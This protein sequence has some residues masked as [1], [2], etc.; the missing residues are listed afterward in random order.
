MNQRRFFV[1]ISWIAISFLIV[2][3]CSKLT[4][5]NS[6]NQ[7]AQSQNKQSKSVELTVSAAASIQ[8]AM[9]EVGKAYQEEHTNKKI[10]YNFANSGTLTQQIKQG[11]PVD[12]FISANEKFM[13]ELDKINLLFPETRK[14]ILKNDIV[15]IIPKKGNI[16]NISNFQQLTSSNIKRFSIGEPESVP[17]GRYARQVLTSLKIY[18]Q[19]KPKTVFAKDVRQVLAYIES[20]NVDAGIVYATDAKISNQVKVVANA[21]ENTHKSIVYPVAVIKLTRNPE[22]AKEF[23]QFLFSNPATDLFKKYGFQIAG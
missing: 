4:S 16:P 20:G 2:V 11:A 18:H 8:D 1:L 14:N 15:L 9:K 17:A 19:L 3:G 13:D 23:V 5:N 21:P 6:G 7:A 22:A 12:I 10:I